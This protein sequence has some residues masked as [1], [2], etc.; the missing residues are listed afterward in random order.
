MWLC[1]IEYCII[2]RRNEVEVKLYSTPYHCF[3]PH[4]FI[5]QKQ[6]MFNIYTVLDLIWCLYEA[7]NLTCLKFNFSDPYITAP[8]SGIYALVIGI[9]AGVFGFAVIVIVTLCICWWIKS[10]RRTKERFERAESIRSSV[11]G[12]VRSKSVISRSTMSMLTAGHS[13]LRLDSVSSS[14]FGYDDR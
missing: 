3:L 7:V 2:M 9:A 6:N 8:D 11:R 4:C 12:S 5:F 14:K 1:C 13:K 10:K